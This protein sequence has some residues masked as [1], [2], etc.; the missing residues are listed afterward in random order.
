[1]PLL[2]SLSVLDVVV[3]QLVAAAWQAAGI[4]SGDHRQ[5]CGRQNG[6]MERAWVLPDVIRPPN[7]S[8]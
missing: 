3:R 6:N 7:L 4:L 8:A 2:I 5:C 1:M